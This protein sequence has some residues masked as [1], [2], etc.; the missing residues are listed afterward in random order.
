MEGD[1]AK[2]QP[3]DLTFAD[4]ATLRIDARFDSPAPPS[5]V[6]AVLADHRGAIE[7]IGSGVSKIQPTSTPEEGVGAT[8]T[9]WFFGGLGRLDETFIAWDEPTVWSFTGTAFRPGVFTKFVERVSLEPSG[10]DGCRITYRLALETRPA[11]R[12][13]DGIIRRVLAWQPPRVLA[14]LSS[15][16]SRR[17][18][19]DDWQR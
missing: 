9:V 11:I 17:H 13:L 8:R 14:S 5:A 3:Q 10:G 7:W 4:T 1:M 15:A 19:A 18:P 6:F 12:P 2:L 16:A